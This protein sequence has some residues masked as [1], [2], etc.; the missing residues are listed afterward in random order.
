MA[1]RSKG[2]KSKTHVLIC[3]AVRKCFPVA[4]PENGRIIMTGIQNVDDEYL[5]GQVVRFECTGTFR[6]NGSEQI[7]CTNKGEWSAP[8]PKCIGIEHLTNA[9]HDDDDDSSTEIIC[10]APEVGNGQFHPRQG[11]YR[12]DDEIHIRCENGYRL[13]HIGVLNTRHT[14][15]CTE[16]GWSPS[17]KCI[18]KCDG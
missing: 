5:F 13:E 11:Q 10:S 3:V 4:A 8:V 9:K 17:P 7:V 1:R 2:K 16:T 18:S 12:N 6:I 15:R 14:S